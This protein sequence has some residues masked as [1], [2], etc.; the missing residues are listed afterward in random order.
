MGIVRAQNVGVHAH[1]GVV[2]AWCLLVC[3]CVTAAFVPPCWL[4]CVCAGFVTVPLICL[5][6]S[7]GYPLEGACS[8][9]GASMAM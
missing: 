5:S 7:D 6:V 9:Q 8:S 2:F 3:L 1:I 4:I